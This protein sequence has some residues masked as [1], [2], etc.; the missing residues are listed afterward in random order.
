MAIS[1]ATLGN[2]DWFARPAIGLLNSFPGVDTGAYS[3]SGHIQEG[4]PRTDN[5][6]WYIP[7][8][9]IVRSDGYLEDGMMRYLPEHYVLNGHIVELK[10]FLRG[11]FS[12]NDNY[13]VCPLLWIYDHPHEKLSFTGATLVVNLP[14]SEKSR[15]VKL[16]E[17]SLAEVHNSYLGRICHNKELKFPGFYTPK[18]SFSPNYGSQRGD[19]DPLGDYWDNAI[20]TVS[21]EGE[22]VYELWRN[23]ELAC[24]DILG[25]EPSRISY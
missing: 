9:K 22:R 25:T 15:D 13:S 8:L 6:I 21:R 3:C 23:I 5:A 24:C 1:E 11:A 14:E 7:G 2:I 4:S 12:H 18:I 17:A 16:L 19:C 20:K 10:D